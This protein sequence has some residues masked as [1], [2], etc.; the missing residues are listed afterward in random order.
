MAADEH[1]YQRALSALWREVAKRGLQ[2]EDPQLW[3]KLAL[4]L[5]AETVPEIRRLTRRVGGRPAT[6]KTSR[7]AW[8]RSLIFASVV[9]LQIEAADQ[10]QKLSD[11]DACKRLSQVWRKWAKDDPQHPLAAWL[12]KRSPNTLRHDLS[13][14]KK[15]AAAD[16]SIKLRVEL[17]S[18]YRGRLWKMVSPPID[19]GEQAKG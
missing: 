19:A 13:T 16:Q 9:G 11:E 4:Q 2:R 17:L 6:N 7:A 3:F 5:I 18:M 12:S 10:S 15:E 1:D 8:N 14:A